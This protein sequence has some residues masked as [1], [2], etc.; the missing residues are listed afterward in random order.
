MN[1]AKEIPWFSNK[2][3]GRLRLDGWKYIFYPFTK[4]RSFENE[5][6]EEG[7]ITHAN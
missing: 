4:S 7:R 1:L 3:R 2:I 6:S 5:L